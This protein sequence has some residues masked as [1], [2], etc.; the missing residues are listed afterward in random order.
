[1]LNKLKRLLFHCSGADLSILLDPRCEVE[2]IKYVSI[3]ATVLGTALLASLSGGYAAFTA[4][5]N[6]PLA[7]ALGL[8]WGLLI[9]NLDRYVVTTL[10]KKVVPS[11]A[12]LAERFTSGVREFGRALPRLLL[13]IFI[14]IIITRPIELKLFEREIH[15]RID[16]SKQALLANLQQQM[17]AE[18]AELKRLEDEN[19]GLPQEVRAKERLRDE[20]RNKMMAEAIG[21]QGDMLTGRRGEGPIFKRYLQAFNDAEAELVNLRATVA[22]QAEENERRA[23][24]LRGQRD[25]RA[26]E[27]RLAIA[28]SDGLLARLEAH[29]QLATEKPP[30]ARA[31]AFIVMLFL[32]L[33]MAPIIV[34]LLSDRGPY[35]E[36]YDEHVHGVAVESRRRISELEDE[37]ET[38][39]TLSRELHAQRRAALLML[40]RTT[41]AS[42]ETLASDELREARRDVAQQYIERWKWENVKGGRQAS[43]E[44]ANSGNVCASA[45][46]SSA[47][48]NML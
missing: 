22:K 1:M 33:E 45:P 28:S 13:A 26:G 25:N 2:H 35:D 5:R 38:S 44:T 20:L 8:L 17:D 43:S 37:T 10:K 16:R 12:R 32:L 42:L 24:P 15:A 3:G 36:L 48:T 23:A 27:V 9:F 6:V 7:A 30:V 40:S 29:A 46:P 21:D 14:S 31:S 34:K 41:L 47:A 11:G 18:F 19:R 39:T 4:F